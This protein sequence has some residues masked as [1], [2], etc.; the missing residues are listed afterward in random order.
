MKTLEKHWTN[1]RLLKRYRTACRAHGGHVQGSATVSN[2]TRGC[3]IF[4]RGV[5]TSVGRCT[6]HNLIQNDFAF[7]M[8]LL[9]LEHTVTR[10]HH[11]WYEKT[12]FWDEMAR[13]S[14]PR[15]LSTIFL[16]SVSRLFFLKGSQFCKIME[17][18]VFIV[19]TRILVENSTRKGVSSRRIEQAKHWPN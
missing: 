4:G 5:T 14:S 6:F 10:K 13:I 8:S 19:F 12:N 2:K 18:I 1:T 15:R 17:F 9:L 11:F 16:I 3:Y 7:K